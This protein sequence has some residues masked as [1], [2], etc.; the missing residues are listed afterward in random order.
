MA[1][2]RTTIAAV[3]L[4]TASTSGACSWFRARTPASAEA[5]VF[6]A[7]AQV[8]TPG[9]SLLSVRVVANNRGSLTWTLQ[10]GQCSLN[11][12]VATL[13]P[14]A[15]RVWDYGRWRSKAN[16]RAL[17]LADVAAL[18]LPPGTSAS[19]ENLQRTVRVRDVLGDSLL[20]GQYRVTAAV[21]L[22]NMS[23]ADITAG[24]VMLKR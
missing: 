4:V 19:A 14:A 8:I 23:A 11:F 13:P 6:A 5:V 21:A 12:R 16:P 20:P 18:R 2:L 17:C 3:F 7:Q 22:D 24:E 10:L 1:S 9:D 15:P